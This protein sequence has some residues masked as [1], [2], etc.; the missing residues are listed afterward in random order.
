[1]STTKRMWR[2]IVPTFK[3]TTYW[4]AFVLNAIVAGIS[5][6][7][8]VEVRF[9]LNPLM[10]RENFDEGINFAITMALSFVSAFL[11]YG[12]MYFMFG[13]GGGQLTGEP[14]QRQAHHLQTQITKLQKQLHASN[15]GT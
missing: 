11:T 7:V 15:T 8:T 5:T 6:A 10:D 12:V 1:M 9:I 4:K 2:G 13:F 3:E 14:I